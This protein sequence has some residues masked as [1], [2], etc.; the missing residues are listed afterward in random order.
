M[1]R[2][3]GPA[4]PQSLYYG[5]FESILLDRWSPGSRS[6]YEIVIGIVFWPGWM[7]P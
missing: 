1:G 4:P 5:G 7:L 2:L 3:C 6:V